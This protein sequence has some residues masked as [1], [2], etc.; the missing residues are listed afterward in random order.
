MSVFL[1]LAFITVP[2]Y[3]LLF[4]FSSLPALPVLCVSQ[5]WELRTGKSAE[6]WGASEAEAEAF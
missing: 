3:L 5:A 1:D 6:K 4:V 2:F